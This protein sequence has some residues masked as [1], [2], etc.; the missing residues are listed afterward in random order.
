MSKKMGGRG[1]VEFVG[2]ASDIRI[3]DVPIE[4]PDPKFTNPGGRR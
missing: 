4:T 1:L 3:S 2:I